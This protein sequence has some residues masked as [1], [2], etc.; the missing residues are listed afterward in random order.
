L[1]VVLLQQPVVESRV[2]MEMAR[3]THL[4][5]TR[6]ITLVRRGKDL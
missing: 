2:S 3:N 1:V 5:L 4:K 6:K